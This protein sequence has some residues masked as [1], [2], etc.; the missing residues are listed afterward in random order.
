ML[1]QIAN[2]RQY[3]TRGDLKTM[4]WFRVDAD[5][6]HSRKL[7][8]LTPAE[9]WTWICLL[10]EAADQNKAGLV[11]AEI[12]YLASFGGI[13][14]QQMEGVLET[15][16]K[17]RLVE[18][19]SEAVISLPKEDE[20]MEVVENKDARTR[21]RVVGKRAYT[22]QNRTEQL[23]TSSL[24]DSGES[25]PAAGNG[26]APSRPTKPIDLMDLW[27]CHRGSLS[28]AQKMTKKREAQ[29]RV[30]LREEPDPAYWESVV[31]KMA[32]STFC[33][34]GKWANFDWLIVNDT[35]HVKVAE[36]KYD[37]HKAPEPTFDPSAGQTDLSGAW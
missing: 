24:V 2:W 1:L 28:A 7:F 8:G 34:S 11:D 32:A 37:D 4:F 30:R 10:S 17:R 6:R 13:N 35:N 36:G 25:P 3:Q 15:L 21:A 29:C 5:I 33:R 26:E 22:E 27:N 23:E 9:K 16:V 31:C 14:R 12:D 19:I 18:P 20:T